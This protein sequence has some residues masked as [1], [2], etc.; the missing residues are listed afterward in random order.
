MSAVRK[1]GWHLAAVAASIVV[2]FGVL[3][4]GPTGTAEAAH[5]LTANPT[6][7]APGS[8]V[9]ITASGLSAGETVVFERLATSTA[10]GTFVFNGGSTLACTD[11][12][13]CDSNATAGAITVTFFISNNSAAGALSISSSR[14]GYAGDVETVTITVA[15]GAGTLQGLT[16][17]GSSSIG[18]GDSL[19]YTVYG[20]DASGNRV[21]VNNVTMTSTSRAL[22][23]Q[24]AN[25]CVALAADDAVANDTSCT[26]ATTSAST[27]SPTQVGVYENGSVGDTFTITAF[28][29][30]VGGTPIVGQREVTIAGAPASLTISAADTTV[31]TSQTV[32]VNVLDA[33]GN[34]VGPTTV[35]VAVSEG[36]ISCP[37]NT[38]SSGTVSC[39]FVAPGSPQD[40]VITAI[41]DVPASTQD[42][43]GTET[44]TVVGAAPPT[45]T[46]T[47]TPPAGGDAQFD[48]P[49]SN[50]GVNTAVWGG[51][52]VD[53]LSAATAAAGGISVTVF[54][55]G[56][57]K[58]FIPGA[59]AFVNAEFN[60]AFPGG[61]VPAGT[62]VLVVR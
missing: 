34:P 12:G 32:E 54:V 18:N 59:P 21:A 43:I 61:N 45:A 13:A 16:V 51:G 8:V 9:Q 47:A 28:V 56:D 60:A 40:V 37:T 25:Q 11:G 36:V 44:I 17:A 1:F 46:P 27:T 20:S 10:T 53:Q 2:A 15:A 55:G 31:G 6:T 49:I 22:L 29:T 38:T 50:I 58:V 33:N 7:A 19:N 5:T 3:A 41:A 39:T 35:T 30:P 23:A 26:I 24:V 14:A 57:A 42:I 48:R 52:T 62:I 4:A